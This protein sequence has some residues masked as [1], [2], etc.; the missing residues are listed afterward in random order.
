LRNGTRGLSR[1]KHQYEIHASFVDAREINTMISR[2]SAGEITFTIDDREELVSS[3]KELFTTTDVGRDYKTNYYTKE[4]SD[5][6]CAKM[7]AAAQQ[8]AGGPNITVRHLTSAL[9]LLISSG[10]IQQKNVVQSAQLDEPE[11]DN[12]PRGRDGKLLTDSQIKWQ[13]Y[14]VWSQTA[15]SSERKIRMNSDPGYATFV[16]KSLQAEM[17]HEIDGAVQVGPTSKAKATKELEAFAQKFLVE[18]SSNL[19]PINGMVS[20]AGEKIPWP[21][22]NDLLNKATAARL[23]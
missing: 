16:R 17:T 10:E 4:R 21:T 19:R 9:E 15:N 6:D 8:I 2:N 1:S 22:F 5:D 18:P 23:L 12:R 20:L 14:G 13:E 7:I 11:V 3:F